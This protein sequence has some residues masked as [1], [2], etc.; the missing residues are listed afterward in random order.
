MEDLEIDYYGTIMKLKRN[1]FYYHSDARTIII[2]PWD[3]NALSLLKAI[4]KS[5]LG[6][7]PQIEGG[8]IRIAIPPL[9][10]EEEKR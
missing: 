2:Q 6:L 10:E 7:N 3:K 8:V 9:T 1:D 5:D 4:C